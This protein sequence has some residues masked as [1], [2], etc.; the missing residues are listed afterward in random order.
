MQERYIFREMLSEIKELADQYKMEVDQ[1]K[2]VVNAEELKKDLGVN[3][4]IDFI[5]DKAVI[6][7]ETVGKEEEAKDDTKAE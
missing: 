7:T 1:I 6:T 3:K 4:A 2:A 5:K